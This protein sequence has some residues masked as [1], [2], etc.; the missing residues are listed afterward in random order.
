V[1]LVIIS[2][3]LSSLRA[4]VLLQQARYDF[5]GGAIITGPSFLPCYNRALIAAVIF[6]V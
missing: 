6:L 3:L 4:D 5:L 2:Q 1:P